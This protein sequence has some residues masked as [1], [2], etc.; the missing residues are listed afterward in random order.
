MTLT[1]VWP[2]SW[3]SAA[4]DFKSSTF[5]PISPPTGIIE[6]AVVITNPTVVA[7]GIPI[8][9][10]STDTQVQSWFDRRQGSGSLS[11]TGSVP[12]PLTTAPS[13]TQSVTTPTP[14]S[15]NTQT[16]R[17]WGRG[18]GYDYS[19]VVLGAMSLIATIIIS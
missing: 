5:W 2:V 16:S 11:T 15:T 9:W 1:S 8:M 10:E 4:G 14:T 7:E 12:T 6:S 19:M 13:P 3:V 18:R 17:A